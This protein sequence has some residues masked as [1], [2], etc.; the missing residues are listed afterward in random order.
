MASYLDVPMEQKAYRALPWVAGFSDGVGSELEA[1]MSFV[2]DVATEARLC[3][4]IS[5]WLSCSQL[6]TRS[7]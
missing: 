7:E 4:G 2:V 6:F 1:E 3:H 5:L